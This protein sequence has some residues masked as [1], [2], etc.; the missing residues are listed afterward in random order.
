VTIGNPDHLNTPRQIYNDQQQ[1]AWR[2]DQQEPFGSSPPNENP[3]GIGTFEFPLRF[4]GQYA[5]K[6]T[7][8][9]YNYFRD[10]DPSLGRYEESDPIGLA[11]GINTYAY[12]RSNPLRDIDPTGEADVRIENAMRAAGM[13]IPIPPPGVLDWDCFLKC[14][15]FGKAAAAATTTVVINKAAQATVGTAIGAVAQGAKVVSNN[16]ATI[17]IAASYGLDYCWRN[18]RKDPA[19]CPPPDPSAAP[20][21][22]LGAP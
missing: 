14:V 19:S 8:L 13:P 12:V 17:G 7:N 3:A 16:P 1:L 22:F 10:Y 9:A 20:P 4:P 6:E 11:G 21:F 2:W 18:C 5:D 15:V